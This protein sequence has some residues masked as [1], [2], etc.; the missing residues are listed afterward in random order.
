MKTPALDLALTEPNPAHDHVTWKP[1]PVPAPLQLPTPAAGLAAPT[2]PAAV[3]QPAPPRRSRLAW[4]VGALL[5]FAAGAFAVRSLTAD[6]AG[7]SSA[8]SAGPGALPPPAPTPAPAP[9]LSPAPQPLAM[10]PAEPAPAPLSPPPPP[11][12]PERQPGPERAFVTITPALEAEVKLDGAVISTMTSEVKP[13]RHTVELKAKQT[14]L[15][16]SVA[17]TLKPGERWVYAPGVGTLKVDL[18]P[19]GRLKVNGAEVLNGFS[20]WTGSV[21][22][23]RYELEAENAEA[24]KA[25]K[26]LVQVK[27]GGDAFETF[28]FL[29][30]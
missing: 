16:L 20:S 2:D 22:E 15:R 8:P 3:A 17:R 1:T 24:R 10:R 12:K 11:V 5:I 30:E 26:R 7:R 28:N 21:W 4:A 23:G 13:G 29:A 25:F 9:T 27:A 18:V 6:T 19:F 14:G